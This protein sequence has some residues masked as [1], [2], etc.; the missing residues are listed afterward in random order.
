MTEIKKWNIRGLKN[1]LRFSEAAHIILSSKLRKVMRLTDK[2]F[3]MKRPKI[4]MISGSQLEDSDT[5]SNCSMTASI[6]SDYCLYMINR[7]NLRTF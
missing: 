4:C 7:K 3:K 6:K 1:N 5:Q 2:F